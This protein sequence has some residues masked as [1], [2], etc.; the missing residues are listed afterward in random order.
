MQP[1]TLLMVVAFCMTRTGQCLSNLF[2]I[3]Y[4]AFVPNT[5]QFDSIHHEDSFFCF[6]LFIKYCYHIFNEVYTQPRSNR[7]SEALF[8]LQ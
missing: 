1:A 6:V 8:Y 2:D 5:V 7:S 3:H 4:P